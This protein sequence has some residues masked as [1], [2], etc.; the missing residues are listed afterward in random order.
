MSK[1]CAQ[2][3]FYTESYSAA[4]IEVESIED[5]LMLH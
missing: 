3:S 1:I 2:L 5:N 4:S